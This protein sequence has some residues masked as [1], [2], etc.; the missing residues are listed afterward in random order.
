MTKTSL[1]VEFKEVSL[2]SPFSSFA[3]SRSRRIVLSMIKEI[4]SI[5][6]HATGLW[7]THFNE[8]QSLLSSD[9]LDFRFLSVI[10]DLFWSW[11]YFHINRFVGEITLM[12][13]TKVHDQL[14]NIV[15]HKLL[16]YWVYLFLFAL[17]RSKSSNS[18]VSHSQC[19]KSNTVSH[20]SKT[21][22]SNLII[23]IIFSFIRRIT[24]LTLKNKSELCHWFKICFNLF[25][26]YLKFKSI[27]IGFIFNL[28]M[29][30]S[31]FNV[32]ITIEI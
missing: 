8:Y 28:W 7:R 2:I 14:C 19:T 13:E 27:F 3:P 1:N 21:I 32:C 4:V 9:V 22:I 16:N 6:A 12:F 31:K 5:K 26:I 24:K 23:Y 30:Q 29:L 17:N 11:S 20:N 10:N 15:I 18:V 25:F